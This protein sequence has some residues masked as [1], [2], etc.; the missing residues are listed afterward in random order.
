MSLSH[1]TEPRACKTIQSIHPQRKIRHALTLLELIVSLG[2]LA[3]LST[4]AVRSLDPIADQSR[5]EATQRVLESMRLATIG[6][7]NIRQLN[8]QRILEGFVADTGSFPSD[9][10]DLVVQPVGMI[11]HS[12]QTFDSNNDSID[13]VSLSSGWRG[14]YLQLGV[15]Q[16]NIV[17]GWGRPL[18]ITAGAGT[19]NFQSTGSDGD[20]I[21]PED[22]YA[23]DLS[24]AI[25]NSEFESTVT[26]RLFDIDGITGLRIIPSLLGLQQ[27]GILLYCVNGNG[28]T[29]GAVE[30]VMIPV[31]PS[32]SFEATKTD[33]VHGTAAARGVIWLDLNLN[34]QLDVGE[35]IARTTYVHYFTV[36]S[37]S[38][39]R[40]EME[41]RL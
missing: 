12:I 41:L 11:S 8:G 17:D 20:S 26:F 40:I 33:L 30:E 36:T 22:G 39:V 24:I 21:L 31:G 3:I 6:D 34:D 1:C 23:S 18:T 5:F 29:S 13:D 28:G 15:G 9:P 7:S 4:I 25:S 37:N 16:S 27:S 10:D 14:P 32:G 19:V 35:L 38:D 2:I